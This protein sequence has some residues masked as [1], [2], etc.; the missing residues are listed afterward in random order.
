M[1]PASVHRMTRVHARLARPTAL[2][3]AIAL[4][5]VVFAL[6]LRMALRRNPGVQLSVLQRSPLATMVLT[7]ASRLGD[8]DK[9]GYASW[10]IGGDCDDRDP[11]IHPG[12]RDIPG[13]GIDQNC[14]GADARAFVPAP[15]PEAFLA[16]RAASPQNL[17]IVHLDA[18]RLDHLSS[19]GYPRP[20][21]AVLD[22]FRKDAVW[23]ERAYTPGPQT[24][25]ALQSIFTGLD[26]P[27]IPLA[28]APAEE[29]VL[30]PQI[31]TVAEAL[32]AKGYEGDDAHGG[33]RPRLPRMAVALV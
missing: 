20:T 1:G 33:A 16:T 12:A 2:L 22:R 31:H 23:F 4:V 8:R 24:R 21:S 13:D 28:P 32:A 27:R 6:G 9:D 14:S 5:T 29:F 7:E 17:V 26:M 10:P 3:G 11:R 15:Q 18:L 19:E 25:V 30:A